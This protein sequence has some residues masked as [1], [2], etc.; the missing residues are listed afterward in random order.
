ML[1]LHPSLSPLVT[2]SLFPVSESA[3]FFLYL[4]VCSIYLFK[5]FSVSTGTFKKNKKILMKF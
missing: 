1:P 2:S 3:A 4:L 5:H